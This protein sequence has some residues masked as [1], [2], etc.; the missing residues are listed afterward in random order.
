MATMGYFI[1]LAVVLVIIAYPI[2]RYGWPKW[3]MWGGSDGGS[4]GRH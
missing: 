1:P 2:N 3:W 4:S